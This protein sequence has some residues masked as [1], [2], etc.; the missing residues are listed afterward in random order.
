MR[1]ALVLARRGWGRT[2]PNPLV[3]AVVGRDGV[4]VGEGYHVAYGGPHA[5]V[6][7]L[8][9][10]GDRARGADVYVTLEPCAHHGKTP[11]CSDALI[12]AGVRRVIY[13]VPDPN[14][15]AGGGAARLRAA[16]IAVTGDVERAAA[17]ELNAPFLFAHRGAS[18]PWVTLKL[19]VS[20]EGA[21]APQ[22]R[23]QR[24]LTGEPARKHVHLLRAGADAIAVG[25]G[26]VL[27]DDPELTVRKGRRPRV[28]PA[29][30]VFDARARLP[31][32]AKL[33]RTA[34]KVPTWLVVQPT[35]D[36]NALATL[37]QKGV[38]VFRADA[39]GDQLATLRGAGVQHL[40]VEGG[41]GLAGSLINAGFVDRLIIFQA[42]VLLGA[43]ALSAF[44]EVSTGAAFTER[45]RLM[46]HRAFA[47][48]VMSVYA[49]AD[50]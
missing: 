6:M 24:W 30:V 44:G 3:G 14:P 38:R 20:L 15:V 35:A 2:A 40:F 37:E 46:D 9:A 17:E 21:L 13:A 22:D 29:R 45:W 31:L 39:L 8:A 32:T 25:I 50:R 48:D 23:S 1:R 26:T 34:K 49:P 5:E 18:R 36:S 16:G 12:A 4:I 7:A 43:G 11:P 10:A 27:A 33:V 28:K 47:D 19:A 41:A 42:P